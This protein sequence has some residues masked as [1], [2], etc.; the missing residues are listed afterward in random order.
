MPLREHVKA[1]LIDLAFL[2]AAGLVVLYG[3]GAFAR[4]RAHE[5]IDAKLI[6]ILK[7]QAEAQQL[8]LELRCSAAGFTRLEEHDGADSR[9]DR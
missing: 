1:R 6:E 8:D 7:S 9:T 4:I 2:L 5:Q 3:Y